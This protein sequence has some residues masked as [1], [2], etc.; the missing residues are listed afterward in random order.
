MSQEPNKTLK[1][2]LDARQTLTQTNFAQ[3]SFSGEHSFSIDPNQTLKQTIKET[4]AAKNLL[5]R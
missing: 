4:M 1:E 3:K 2:G 5:R